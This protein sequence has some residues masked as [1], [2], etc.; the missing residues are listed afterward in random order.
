MSEPIIKTFKYTGNGQDGRFIDLGFSP[1]FILLKGYSTVYGVWCIPMT[2]R[3]KMPYLGKADMHIGYEAEKR[4]VYDFANPKLKGFAVSDVE[5]VNSNGVVYYGIA[6]K[7][8]GSGILKYGCYKGND[9]A[10]REIEV[11]FRPAFVLLKRDNVYS[12]NVKTVKDDDNVSHQLGEQAPV[13][14]I[15]TL[16][17]TGFTVSANGNINSSGGDYDYIAFKE[18]DWMDIIEYTGDGQ[19]DR[20]IATMKFTPNF[21]FSRGN[22]ALHPYFRTDLFPNTNSLTFWNYASVSDRLQ[23]LITNGIQV[24]NGSHVNQNGTKFWVVGFLNNDVAEIGRRKAVSE[25]RKYA[26]EYESGKG[27]IASPHSNL[28]FGSPISIEFLYEHKHNGV[29]QFLYAKGESAFNYQY[30]AYIDTSNNLIVRFNNKSWDTG[31]RIPDQRDV[32]IIIT[33]DNVKTWQV[34]I[35]GEFWKIY[36]NTSSFSTHPTYEMW[37]GGRKDANEYKPIGEM[38]CFRLYNTVLTRD[39]ALGRYRA[40]VYNEADNKLDFVEE[41][42]FTK[43]QGNLLATNHSDNNAVLTD[44]IWKGI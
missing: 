29:L 15:R 41:W 24:G 11:G 18:N 19:D 3:G 27:V 23:A 7:D 10:D 16:T 36:E 20:N 13:D 44:C 31:I 6:I 1:D 32:H 22:G 28:D 39:E 30:A 34:F 35:N 14:Y 9:T 25:D 42:D 40:A 21:A 26:L 38:S 43:G 12:G 4:A 5:E 2:W 33:F 8:N 17:D 37:I